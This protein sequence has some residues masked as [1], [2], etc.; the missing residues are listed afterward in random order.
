[1]ATVSPRASSTCLSSSSFCS[2]VRKVVCWEE[3]K[4]E[5]EEGQFEQ[6]DMGVVLRCWDKHTNGRKRRNWMNGG[7]RR[8]NEEAGGCGLNLISFSSFLL[9]LNLINFFFFF[10]FFFFLFVV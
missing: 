5:E 2:R 3:K 10:F 8:R 6:D 9:L 1:M 4:K 7:K